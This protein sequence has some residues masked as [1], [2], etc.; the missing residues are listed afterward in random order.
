[1]SIR[2]AENARDFRA[3]KMWKNGLIS[4]R[5]HPERL[6]EIIAFFQRHW[7]TQ[8]SAM[9]YEDCIRSCVDA[10][11]PLPQWYVVE[12]GQDIAAGFGLIPNDFISRMDLSPWLCALFV[13]PAFRGRGLGSWLCHV[14]RREAARLGFA[15]LYLCTD[16]VGYYERSGFQYIADGW[17]PWGERS[18]IYG[19]RTTAPFQ[20]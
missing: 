20:K 11:S 16:H 15:R 2:D 19:A 14:A 17:H 8:D 12:F 9:V 6:D 10:P 1:M 3:G 13:E 4:A 7:A 5:E 18:R